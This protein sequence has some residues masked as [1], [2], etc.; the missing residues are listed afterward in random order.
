MNTN[1][2]GQYE[3]FDAAINSLKENRETIKNIFETI[4]TEYE[5]MPYQS[6]EA[7]KLQSIFDQNTVVDFNK[8]C[9][10]ISN[11]ISCLEKAKEQYIIANQESLH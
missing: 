2:Q 11:Y 10:M 1:I 7:S 5:N 3:G 6:R 9:E 4:K 8:C